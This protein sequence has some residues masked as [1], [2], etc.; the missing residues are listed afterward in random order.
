MQLKCTRRAVTSRHSFKALLTNQQKKRCLSVFKQ[1]SK[2]K[3]ITKQA[4]VATYQYKANQD[5][6]EYVCRDS[7]LVLGSKR[8]LKGFAGSI[9]HELSGVME[10]Y[11][12]LPAPW[13]NAFF[14]EHRVYS[15]THTSHTACENAGRSGV[16]RS[17]SVDTDFTLLMGELSVEQSADDC[18]HHST[19]PRFKSSFSTVTFVLWRWRTHVLFHCCSG[20]T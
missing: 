8:P 17:S 1:Y 5:M 10:T 2:K 12:D 6:R 14:R 20:P 15:Q 7:V 16:I 13:T 3:R 9:R 11:N 19:S 18:V 4:D